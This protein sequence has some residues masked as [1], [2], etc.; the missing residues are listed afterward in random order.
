MKDR[1]LKL[2]LGDP[3]GRRF[4][5]TARKELDF[6]GDC[7]AFQ[8]FRRG[9]LAHGLAWAVNWADVRRGH[10]FPSAMTF[11]RRMIWEAGALRM[12]PVDDVAGL[13]AAPLGDVATLRERLALPDGLAEIAL[14]CVGPFRL[15]LDHPDCPMAI[16]HDG[17]TLELE[18]AWAMHRRV[19]RRF[20]VETGA[21]TSLSV[22]VDVGLV[23]IYADG[24]RFVGTKRVPS[25][26]PVSALRLEAGPNTD[27]RVWRLRPQT[28]APSDKT[29]RASGGEG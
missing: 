14:D 23:E 2:C 6:V 29:P 8:G 11:P 7:Y 4:E 15:T 16:V 10:D 3:D 9:G 20:V 21:L 1:H 12:P 17:Q 24:G 5:A 19:P 13:R 18:A 26:A 27:A 28:G 25:D 22:F